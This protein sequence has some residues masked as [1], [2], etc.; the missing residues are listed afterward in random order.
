MDY[1]KRYKIQGIANVNLNISGKKN[2]P[3]LFGDINLNK[4]SFSLPNNININNVN[5]NFNFN[6]NLITIKDGF[7]PLTPK[8]YVK[9]TGSYNPNTKKLCQIIEEKIKIAN[10]EDGQVL[11]HISLGWSI[12]FED[13]PLHEVFRQADDA[14]YWNKS[15]RK[16]RVQRELCEREKM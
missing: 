3:N 12:G 16:E 2:K 1:V 6:G 10:Q 15:V 11:L 5:S 7:I 8:E 9:I 13:T 4:I 14:M